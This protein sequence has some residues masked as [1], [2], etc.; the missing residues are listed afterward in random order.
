MGLHKAE[1]EAQIGPNH[2]NP[3]PP[4][5]PI[6]AEGS[7]PHSLTYRPTN[8]LPLRRRPLPHEH[9]ASLLVAP[10]LQ[11]LLVFARRFLLA[12]YF[13]SVLLAAVMR[14]GKGIF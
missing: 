11:F 12:S 10:A 8:F 3:S 5:S 14:N 9:D 1:G 2:P 4:V 6:Y 13:C 7:L